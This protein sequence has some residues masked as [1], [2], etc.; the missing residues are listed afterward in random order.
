M[1]T[2]LENKQTKNAKQTNKKTHKC[3]EIKNRVTKLKSNNSGTKELQE[4][5]LK[6]N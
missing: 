4:Y 6:V 1:H 3:L 2:V 5:C